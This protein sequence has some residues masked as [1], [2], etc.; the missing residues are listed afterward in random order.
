VLPFAPNT[1]LAPMEGVTSPPLRGVFARRG[2]IGVVCTEFVRVTR[3]PLS[4]KTLRKHIAHAPGTRLSV[5]VMGNDIEQMAEATELVARAGADIVD[6]NLG[7]PAPK[8]VRKGVGSAM[9]KDLD[10]MRVV[11]EK[12]RERTS[13]PLSA[14]IRAGFDDSS[15][16]LMIGRLLQEAGI[17]F[18]TVHPR[19]RVDFYDGV[20]DWRI[21]R[22]LAQ[23]LRIPVVGNGDIWYASDLLRI[24]KE[25]GC[26]G[27]MLGRPA[28]RNPWIFNQAAALE[29][30]EEPFSPCG[31]DVKEHIWALRLA[32]EPTVTR[33]GLIG[34]LKEQLRYLGR[35]VRD[36]GQFLRNAMRSSSLEELFQVVDTELG[37]LSAEALDL[38]ASPGGL[39][40]SGCVSERE[41]RLPEDN[42]L[43]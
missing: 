15:R 38:K 33:A 13:G 16:V 19:R 18:L 32:L 27:V 12:M 23:E 36:R 20:A 42:V 9:L 8:A 2:D 22:L 28:L 5:Q 4:D 26:S 40:R 7:C 11:V 21:I 10:L 41:S 24:V 29:R 14:K 6:I 30:G 39:E 17:N 1:M 37:P 3:Q 34:L 25:T 35:A 31:A 43:G